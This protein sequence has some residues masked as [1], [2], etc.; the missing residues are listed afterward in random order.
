MDQ[1][2]NQMREKGVRKVEDTDYGASGFLGELSVER[3]FARGNLDLACFV[4]S[5]SNVSA[6]E[7]IRKPLS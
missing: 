4:R 2:A 3:L 5:N 7:E 1:I 6:L